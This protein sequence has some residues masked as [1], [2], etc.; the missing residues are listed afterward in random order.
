[1]ILT[2]CTT[3]YATGLD[4]EYIWARTWADQHMAFSPKCFALDITE[5]F[6]FKVVPNATT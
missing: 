3:C 1:M 2:T 5:Q 4:A 6:N